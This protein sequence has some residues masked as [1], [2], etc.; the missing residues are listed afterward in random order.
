MKGLHIFLHSVRQVTGN[1]DS[2]LRISALPFAIQVLAALILLGPDMMMD[3]GFSPDTANIG[4]FGSVALNLVVTIFTSL[5]IAIAWHRFVLRNEVP[6]GF[7]PSFAAPRSLAYFGRSFVIGLLCIAVA[8][9]LG[10]VAGVIAAG[11]SGATG[12]GLGSMFILFVLVYLPVAVISYRLSTALPGIALDEERAFSAGWEATKGETE[13]FFVLSVIS[14]VAFFVLSFGGSFLLSFLGTLVLGD[15]S[16]L[17]FAWDV[18][19]GW[20]M[21]MVGLSILTTL[22]GHYIEK[23]PLV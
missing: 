5:W 2:A 8:I 14:V 18:A 16:I 23:R 10:V 22:Y 12:P 17:S 3:S 11:L 20:M 9:P 1:L 7:V 6:Q 15:V 4:Y 19:L 21:L 13:T